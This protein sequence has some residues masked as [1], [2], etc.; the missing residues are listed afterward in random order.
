MVSARGCCRAVQLFGSLGLVPKVLVSANRCACTLSWRLD[1][2]L[3]QVAAQ[4]QRACRVGVNIFTRIPLRASTLFV[5]SLVFGV[6]KFD[7]V[8]GGRVFPPYA[9]YHNWG[10]IPGFT[11]VPSKTEVGCPAT[12]VRCNRA[13]RT[14]VV[15]GW[16]QRAGTPQAAQRPQ[17]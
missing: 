7:L 1:A 15:Q 12:G 5:G 4:R 17:R 13:A 2:P 8:A 16:L 9:A 6:R 11:I 10:T 14:C 3:R